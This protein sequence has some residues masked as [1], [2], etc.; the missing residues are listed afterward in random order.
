MKSRLRKLNFIQKAVTRKTFNANIKNGV[1]AVE[2]RNTIGI[3][4]RL[5]WVLEILAF[6]DE[7]NLSPQF[8]FTYPNSN[9]DYFK[10]FFRINDRYACAD[11]SVKYVKIFTIG[12]LDLGK[13]YDTVL[14]VESASYLIKKYLVIHEDILQEVD[15]FCSRY[16]PDKNILGVH[17]RGTDK[18][19][20]AP[21]VT[22][23]NVEEN[24]KLFLKKFPET[25]GVFI[26][27]DD[28][29]FIRYIENSAVGDLVVCR[30]DTFR[31][32][33]N[34]AI[35]FSNQ[36]KYDIN[37]DAIVNCLLLS[38]CQALIK[39]ASILSAWSVLFNPE[40]LLVMLNNP[41]DRY[42]PERALMEK[43]LYDPV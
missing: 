5:A 14:T 21:A 9:K 31:A 7:K 32:T 24:I 43:V 4:A 35:H 28:D 33:D 29:H 18:S 16:F 26:S 10:R 2:I 38:R 40:I 25:S 42:F 19:T 41:F 27:T 11:D 22:Y 3:G 30:D 36:N 13:N 17:Y 20:E 6:C 39:T 37:R 23:E 34:V 12:E 1:M 8:R 15:A